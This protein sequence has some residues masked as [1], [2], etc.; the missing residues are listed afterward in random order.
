MMLPAFYR[1]GEADISKNVRDILGLTMISIILLNLAV[2]IGLWVKSMHKELFIDKIIP[3]M[4][5]V[6]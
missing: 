6:V 5:K 2:N 3:F 1:I 4:R